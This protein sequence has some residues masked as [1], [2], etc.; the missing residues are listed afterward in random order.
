[1]T[2]G[3]LHR[4]GLGSGDTDPSQLAPQ[5]WGTPVPDRPG[6]GASGPSHP[7]FHFIQETQ[8]LRSEG[9]VS[10]SDTT[11]YQL[12]DGGCVCVCVCVNFFIS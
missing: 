12:S 10:K 5:T 9:W 7:S 3:Y 1:M 8:A 4:L 2:S 11:T 6:P